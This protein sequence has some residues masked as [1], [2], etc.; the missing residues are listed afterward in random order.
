MNGSVWVWEEIRNNLT[1]VTERIVYEHF[2]LF[3]CLFRL[4]INHW[5]LSFLWQF[6]CMTFM[7]DPQIS[8]WGG[9]FWFL[10]ML[11]VKCTKCQIDRN[12][13]DWIEVRMFSVSKILVLNFICIFSSLRVS[14]LLL[15]WRMIIRKKSTKYLIRQTKQVGGWVRNSS[16]IWKTI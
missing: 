15:D 2:S 13:R 6:F 4:G 1:R 5:A 10:N 16:T 9:C 7:Q 12:C 8:M 3:F 14:F 11:S